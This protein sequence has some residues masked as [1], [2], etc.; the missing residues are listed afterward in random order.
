VVF[1]YG[2]VA[3]TSCENR[4]VKS[5]EKEDLSSVLFDLNKVLTSLR[6]TFS[7]KHSVAPNRSAVP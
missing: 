5:T 6:S 7:V 3:Y 2:A 1:D 4:C